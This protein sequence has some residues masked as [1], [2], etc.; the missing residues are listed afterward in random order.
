M[1]PAPDSEALPLSEIVAE[2]AAMRALLD[3]I[4]RVARTSA[5]LLLIGDSGTGKEVLSRAAH[6]ASSRA[7]GPFVAINCGALAESVIESLLFGH[8]RG[9]FTGADRAQVGLFESA[10]G[11]TLLLDEVGELPPSLQVRLLRVLQ[12]GR[13]LPV[14][15]TR[16]RPVDVRIIAATNKDL[17]KLV[18]EG[19]FREDL[20]YRLNVV[21]LR[22]PPLSERRPDLPALIRQLLERAN[23]KYGRAIRVDDDGLAFIAEQPWPGNVRDLAHFLERVVILTEGDRVGRADL[24]IGLAEMRRAS[25]LGHPA[26]D[27]A[28][29]DETVTAAGTFQQVA[30]GLRA[31][32]WW[33]FSAEETVQGARYVR[34]VDTLAVYDQT[35]GLPPVGT[36]RIG[37]DAT[38]AD[39]VLATPEVSRLHA[40]LTATAEEVTIA[41]QGSHNGSY[42]AGAAL[43]RGET[44]PLTGETPVRIGKEWVGVVVAVGCAD[45]E[46]RAFEQLAGEL[47][48]R[49]GAR[50]IEVKAWERALALRGRFDPEGLVVADDVICQGEDAPTPAPPKRPR[51]LTR[52]DLLAAFARAKGNRRKIARELGISPT[53]LYRYERELRVWED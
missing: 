7:G 41:D 52:A 43:P 30:D 48:A 10:E 51:D 40:T 32:A 8:R 20:F 12:E 14:G 33:R 26:P 15:E 45:E 24:K 16:E 25:G 29:L 5:T 38:R 53:T 3:Q 19:R 35:L 17:G 22:V 36:V 21:T 44:R 6:G 4:A 37:R 42:V 23:R 47:S 50:R 1:P 9:A 49:F 2:S 13:I 34:P 28:S 31:V 11:G 18:Q 46:R 27:P 39:F